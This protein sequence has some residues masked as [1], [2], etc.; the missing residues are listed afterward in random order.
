MSPVRRLAAL[1]LLS[2]WL[3]ALL[4]CRLEAAGFAVGTECCDSTHGPETP[5][6]TPTECGDDACDVAEGEFTKSSA[7]GAPAPALCACLLCCV[8]PV[9]APVSAPPTGG[10][11]DLAAAPPEVARTWHFV[12]RAAPAPRAP[13]PALA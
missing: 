10:I 8:D 13:A 9:R 3:P 12:A 11:S 1:L 7:A 6:K 2:L 5:A 4:H